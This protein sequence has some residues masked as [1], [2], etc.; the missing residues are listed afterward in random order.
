M[1]REDY[2]DWTT[3]IY[4]F[5]NI[6][7]HTYTTTTATTIKEKETMYLQ[8]NNGV[9]IWEILGGRMGGGNDVINLKNY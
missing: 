1:Y 9:G 8:E 7:T 6:Y 3:C 5:R 2:A 4:V